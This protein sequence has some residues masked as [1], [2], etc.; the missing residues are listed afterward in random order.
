MNRIWLSAVAVGVFA[1]GSGGAPPG[2]PE[3]GKAGISVAPDAAVV[4]FVL[5]VS[6]IL[7][8]VWSRTEERSK[9]LRMLFCPWGPLDVALGIA[10][11][12]LFLWS[13]SLVVGTLVPKGQRDWMLATTVT[14]VCGVCTSLL[15]LFHVGRRYGLWPR[16]LGLRFD[17]WKRDLTLAGA[18]LFL[19]IAVQVPLGEF[20][21]YLHRRTGEPLQPQ[22]LISQ[23]IEAPS[24]VA[25]AIMSLVAIT[26]APFWEEFIFRGFVQPFLARW[27]GVPGAIVLTAALF[28]A[29]HDP[30]SKFLMVPV[31]L[32]PLALALG[33][34]YHRTQ[35]L[36]APIFLHG[37][38]NL[39]SVLL[40]LAKRGGAG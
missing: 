5:M 26:V 1:A 29:F 30:R 17:N 6:A 14:G 36:A 34:A 39:V 40:I 32:F 15:I 24:L 4:T 37:L 20:F 12:L 19:V 33:Y 8:L 3:A 23:M 25:M 10:G 9:P 18:L 28:S 31:M 27:L 21:V 16:D 11:F 7:F 38:H 13:A 35:R 2:T 22:F